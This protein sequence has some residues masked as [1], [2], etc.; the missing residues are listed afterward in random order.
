MLRNKIY[1]EKGC[2]TAY[3]TVDKLGSMFKCTTFQLLS[4]FL[5]ADEF[6]MCIK[7]IIIH[8]VGAALHTFDDCGNI[9]RVGYDTLTLLYVPEYCGFN[10]N[11]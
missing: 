1:L 5:S 3:Y 8:R 7:G 11:W 10:E 2:F 4:G 6:Q 9:T